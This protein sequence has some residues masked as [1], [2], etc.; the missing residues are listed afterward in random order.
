[1]M[2]TRLARF[3]DRRNAKRRVRSPST[4]RHRQDVVVPSTGNLRATL[5]HREGLPSLLGRPRV[6]LTVFAVAALMYSV[7]ALTVRTRELSNIVALVVAVGSPYTPLVAVFGL[8]LSILSRRNFL[9][10]IAVVVVVA[11]VAIQL[12]WYYFGRAADSGQHADV[13]VLSLNLHKGEASPQAVVG[14]AEEN[15]DV[16]AVS[17]LTPEA[18]MNFSQAGVDEAF[19]Y[20]VLIPASGAKGVGLW[21]RFPLSTMVPAGHRNT[22]IAV[23]RLQI[24]GV[25]F[26]LVV[27][28]IHIMSPVAADANS[29]RGWRMGITATAA[30]LHEFADMAGPAAVIVAGDFNSTPDMRQFRDLLSN[31]Y[32]DAAEETAAGF[33]PTFPSHVWSPPLITIDHVLTRNAGAYSIR[34]VTMPGSDHR[35]LLA[36]VRV[37][38]HPVS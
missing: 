17:E 25:R 38:L 33:A 20:S 4:G 3:P 32:R 13:R 7:I 30:N 14:L 1:M 9:S 16:I 2:S 26:N 22:G 19:P 31:G 8:A 15:A 11:T 35:A 12:P 18:V 29:F 34:T 27:A 6:L 21:S 10:G 23:A 5:A 24:P 37:P 36:T 28:S